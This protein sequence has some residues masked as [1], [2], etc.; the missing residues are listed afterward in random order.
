MLMGSDA[1]LRQWAREVERPDDEIDLARAA[2]EL[3]RI[4]HPDLDVAPSLCRLDQL[5]DGAGVP[6]IGDPRARLS[7]VR[8]HLFEELGFAGDRERYYHERNSFLN[9][10]LER[11]RGIPI[12][13]TLVLIEVGRRVGLEIAGVGL[14]G[15]FVAALDV[16]GERLL[17][18]PFHG[19]EVLT[20]ER[21]REVVAKAVG[22]Q[23]AITAAHLAPVGK[24]ALLARMLRNLESLYLR[25]GRWDRATDVAD[26]LLVLDPSLDGPRRAR[27]AMARL[28]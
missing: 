12:A 14:P 25:E 8:Q 20:A 6:T 27:H 9:E 23:V 22:R 13:L 18:D 10:V 16:E 15:H 17:V 1:R 5:A 11:R 4:G 26:R 3:A 7:G 19:G 2:L 24:R 28:N 21:C